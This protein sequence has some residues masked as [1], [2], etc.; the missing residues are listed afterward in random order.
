MAFFLTDYAEGD[1]TFGAYLEADNRT[2]ARQVALRRGLNERIIGTSAA[3]AIP[4]RLRLLIRDEDWIEA[5][6]EACFL[7]FVGLMS[8][9]LTARDLLGD[10]GLIHELL[11]LARPFTHALGEAPEIVAEDEAERERCKAH[12]AQL[13]AQCEWR[14]PGWPPSGGQPGVKHFVGDEEVEA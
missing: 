9:A 3:E 14:V 1:G 7:G 5:A 12:V 10:R 6:H 11:H 8:G 2:H 13:A 4:H